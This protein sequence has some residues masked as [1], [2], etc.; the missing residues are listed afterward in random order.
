M[1]LKQ[2]EGAKWLPLFVLNDMRS[3]KSIFN[4]TYRTPFIIF[5]SLPLKKN[6]TMEAAPAINTNNIKK[7]YSVTILKS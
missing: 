4:V 3:I 5:K 6:N 7:S 1:E 2:K